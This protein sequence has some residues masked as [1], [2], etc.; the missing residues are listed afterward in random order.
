MNVCWP[1]SV[2][3]QLRSKMISGS[4]EQIAIENELNP[5]HGG[6]WLFGKMCFWIDG[7][8]VGNYEEGTSLRDVMHFTTGIVKYCGR[9]DAGGLCK[10]CKDAAF[11][12]IEG[13][14]FGDGDS[15]FDLFVTD[16][17]LRQSPGTLQVK[18]GVD[19][20]DASCVY[21]LEC[22][23]I[24]RIIFIERVGEPVRAIDLSRGLFGAAVTTFYE[25]LE[26]VHNDAFA[27]VVGGYCNDPRF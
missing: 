23:E 14:I 20:F 24:D 16:E 27:R 17:L 26:S 10:L 7:V 2:L 19:I 9:R 13:T 3:Q 15:R 4:K 22:G 8:R 11:E 6:V 12:I 25:W 21:L 5:N 18:P 1:D